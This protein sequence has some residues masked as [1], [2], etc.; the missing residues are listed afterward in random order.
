MKTCHVCGKEIPE[1][2]EEGY[3]YICGDECL[4]AFFKASGTSDS[5]ME[6]VN[7]MKDAPI[8]SLVLVDTP[9]VYN[10]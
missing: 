4:N 5:E 7:G 1:E 3:L 9:P 2:P 8:G 6:K 10:C